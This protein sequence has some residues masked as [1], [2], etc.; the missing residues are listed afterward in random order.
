MRLSLNHPP[1]LWARIVAVAAVIAAPLVPP[2]HREGKGRAVVFVVD[3]SE[4]VG[5]EGRA[6][7]E[8]YV[9]AAWEHRAGARVGMIAFDGSP[10]ILLGIDDALPDGTDLENPLPRVGPPQAPGT[11]LAAA[12]RLATA[13]LPAAGERRIVLLGDG[14]S[15][16][17]DA[18][19]EVKR[20]EREG[21][22][23]DTVPIGAGPATDQPTVTHVAAR[24]ARVAE[25]EPATITATVRS[26]PGKRVEVEWLRDGRHMRGAARETADVG[27]SGTAEVTFTD[28]HPEPGTHVYH[29][30][31]N[32]EDSGGAG[33][34]A[35]IDVTG[36]ARALIVSLDAECP[37]V[38]KD[39]LEKAE[40]AVQVT[41]LGD[42]GLDA[43]ALSAADLVV[44]ADVPLAPSGGSSDGAGLTPK[45]QEALIDFAQKGGGVMVTGGPFG[46]APEYADAPIA[47]M[48]PVEIENQ[49]Q[50]EDPRVAMAIM[51]DR[52]GSMSAHVGSH[53]KIQLAVEAALAAASTLRPDDRLAL[54]SVD[55]KTTWNHPL[56]SIA[57]LE[58]RRDAIRAID[59]GGGGIYVY[60]ALLDAYAA[61]K[62]ADAP[63]RH[64][65]LFSDTADSEEQAEGCIFGD[66]VG[67]PHSAVELAETARKTGITTSVVGIGRDRDHDTP[68]LRKL[69]AAAGGRFYLT[70]NAT[71]LRRIFVSETR[72]ATRSNLRDGPAVVTAFEDHPI[73]AG[74]DVSAMP[75][76]GG[77]VETRRRS[78]ADT[79]LVTRDDQKPILASWRYGLGKVVALTTD[80]RGDWKSGWS[81]FAGSGQVLRQAVR[82]ALR[83]HGQSAADMRVAVHDRAADLT[84]EL[85]DGPGEAA[86]PP[87]SVEAFA[88]GADGKPHPVAATLERVAPG[89]WAARA[90][91]SGQPFV[92]ARA[93]D[94]AGS[95]VGEAIGQTDTAAEL[96]GIGP[97][98]RALR[99]LAREG[100]GEFD[101]AA[102]AA[103]RPGGPRGREPVPLWPWVLLAAAALACVDLWLRRVG[104]QRS[105]TALPVGAP[106]RAPPPPVEAEPPAQAA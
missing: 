43:A 12:L 40:V 92:I 61:L 73:L 11:D 45:T 35:A 17:G 105:A 37:G 10:E 81:H 41:S 98:E 75:P 72:V 21:I 74:V 50:V 68:F 9:R 67:A 24:E 33:A 5:A 39:A 71:D 15:T 104:K 6:A 32:G 14:R 3:R 89:R 86:A 30:R 18:L 23:V 99:A 34:F 54:G 56:G 19:A 13:A 44:L 51:L 46:F 87:T 57:D 80:L 29:A 27:P 94:A 65:I 62:A 28:P 69:A 59:A 52:S 49:G 102:E 47:R 96:A 66:C 38:L 16:R 55:T 8:R 91:T 42:G 1:S 84:I 78:T 31:V 60:T 2:A 106:V 85:P 93:R 36:K 48:L 79:A 101:P 26:Q 63:V 82:F 97:D 88:F 100:G 20:A 64:V 4:S 77:F 76:L 53:T 103:M 7:A 22:V 83:R 90:R 70:G 58:A 25:G 95:L